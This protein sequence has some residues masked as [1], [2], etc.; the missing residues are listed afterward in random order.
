MPCISDA[1]HQ[2]SNHSAILSQMAQESWSNAMAVD[3]PVSN[4]LVLEILDL[5]F[6]AGELGDDNS[7]KLWTLDFVDTRSQLRSDH[8]VEVIDIGF[9]PLMPHARELSS[10]STRKIW[11]AVSCVSGYQPIVPVSRRKIWKNGTQR[12]SETQILRA[13]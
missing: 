1:F 12:R 4:G 13:V 8:E 7:L 9:V 11:L 3:S 10:G 5:P 2:E 6:E